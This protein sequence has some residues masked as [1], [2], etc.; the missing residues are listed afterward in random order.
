[1]GDHI[2]APP[3][4]QLQQMLEFF[5]IPPYTADALDDNITKKRRRWNHMT[6]SGN[7]AGRQKA[8][9]VLEL[10]QRSRR[11]LSAA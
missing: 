9:E 6:N 11:P 1:M 8:A 7:P 3:W 2:G 10:I 5:G 4:R